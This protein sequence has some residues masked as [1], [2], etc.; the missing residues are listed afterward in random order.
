[1]S[2]RRDNETKLDTE[3]AFNCN[4]IGFGVNNKSN[5]DERAMFRVF[6]LNLNL[7]FKP[8]TTVS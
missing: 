2:K 8:Y 3:N 1:M 7:Y 6:F 5:C 4:Y